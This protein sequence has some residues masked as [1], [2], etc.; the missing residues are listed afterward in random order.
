MK[1]KNPLLD[2]LKKAGMVNPT[3]GSTVE[4]PIVWESDNNKIHFN[5]N[6]AEEDAKKA[7]VEPSGWPYICPI[8]LTGVKK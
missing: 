3:F 8:V 5:T 4:K 1:N 6:T 2:A 7:G